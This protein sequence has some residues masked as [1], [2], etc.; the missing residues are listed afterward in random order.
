MRML[1]VLLLALCSSG[2]VSAQATN[3]TLADNIDTSRTIIAKLDHATQ[4]DPPPNFASSILVRVHQEAT[5]FIA[6]ADAVSTT[7]R[8]GDS[9]GGTSM[10]SLYSQFIDLF[11]Q[12]E[13]FTSAET[14]PLA[15]DKVRSVAI[16]K[17]FFETKT[18]LETAT[19]LQLS[20]MEEQLKSCFS[21]RPR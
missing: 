7:V 1:Y 3:N 4:D 5:S 17:E 9:P 15:L 19:Y 11:D 21:A 13:L 6:L 20:T 16:S 18:F 10:F 2:A 14:R 12:Y 8:R